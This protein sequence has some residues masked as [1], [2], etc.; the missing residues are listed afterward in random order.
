MYR[1][2]DLT[3]EQKHQRRERLDW[4]GLLAQLSVLVPLLAVQ[5]YFLAS[6]VRRNLAQSNGLDQT[7]SSPHTKKIRD[8]QYFDTKQFARRWRT[9]V[10]WCGDS[11]H[12][13]GVSL[14][15]KGELLGGFSWM[16]WLTILS[17]LQTGDGKWS[18]FFSSIM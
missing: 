11:I 9:V 12:L 5:I 13:A 7:P 4:Y 10:W 18:S 16:A 14:G 6:W 17:F 3:S 15:T 2:V 8:E 1:F